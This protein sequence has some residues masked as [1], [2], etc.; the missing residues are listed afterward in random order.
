M[1]KRYKKPTY[2]IL[3]FLLAF[4]AHFTYHILSVRSSE[5]VARCLPFG[6]NAAPVTLPV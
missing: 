1:S 4:H 2:L 3:Y 6:L 5:M